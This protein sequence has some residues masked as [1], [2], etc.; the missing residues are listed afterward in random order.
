[1]R[2]RERKKGTSRSYRKKNIE[3]G[4]SK[5]FV[6]TKVRKSTRLSITLRCIEQ[7]EEIESVAYKL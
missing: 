1:M 6:A 3:K 2:E 4:K 7:I 5:R